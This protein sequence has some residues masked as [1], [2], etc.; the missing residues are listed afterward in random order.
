MRPDGAD[1]TVRRGMYGKQD[2]EVR[3]VWVVFLEAGLINVAVDGLFRQ[4]SH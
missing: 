4:R 1:T 2:A 3:A